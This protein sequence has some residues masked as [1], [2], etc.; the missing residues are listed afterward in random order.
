MA[1]YEPDMS[2]QAVVISTAT[3]GNRIWP[4]YPGDDSDFDCDDLAGTEKIEDPYVR[5][6]RPSD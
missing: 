5:Y 6:A 4:R 2:H 3:G 1:K